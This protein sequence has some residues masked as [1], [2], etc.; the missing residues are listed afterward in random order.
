MAVPDEKDGAVPTSVDLR[1]LIKVGVRPHFLDYLVALWDYRHFVF[2]DAKASVQSGNSRDRLGSIWLILNPVLNGLTFYLIFGVLLQVDRGIENFIGF[3]II[4][5]F[6][7]Q[8]SSRSISNG[9]RA[10]QSNLKVVQAFNFPRA[11]LLLSVNIRELLASVPVI[12]TMLVLILLL[13]P[14]EEITWLWF[15]VVPALLLQTVFNL[16]IGL[17]L[18]RVVSRVNDVA[19]VISFVM[20]ILMYAS[21]VMFPISLFDP[22]PTVQEAIEVNPLYQVLT[23]VRESVL[24]S[25]VPSWES[26]AILGAWALG[27]LAVGMVFFWLAEETYGRDE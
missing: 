9:A 2:F 24:Y 11:T 15:L 17:I 4:G 7:F 25:E 5:V 14:A 13:E 8:M 19:N 12:I 10:I 27:A 26:W 20:R 22:Y 21:C 6:L 16:G 3:L 18:A 1:T 23:I